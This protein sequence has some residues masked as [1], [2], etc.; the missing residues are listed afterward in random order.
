[1]TVK[2][3]VLAL[4]GTSKDLEPVLDES[5]LN[6]GSGF[7][8]GGDSLLLFGEYFKEGQEITHLQSL[9]HLLG[10]IYKF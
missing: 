7:C 3:G 8:E 2:V 10:G 6:C 1:V 9:C 5:G 4:I